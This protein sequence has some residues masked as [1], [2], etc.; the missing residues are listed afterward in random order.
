MKKILD[1]DGVFIGRMQLDNCGYWPQSIIKDP[2]GVV[3]KNN[4]IYSYREKESGYKE[5]VVYQMVWE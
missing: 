3:V 2:S 1:S 4:R 5:L